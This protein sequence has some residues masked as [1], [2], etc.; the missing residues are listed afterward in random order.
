MTDIIEVTLAA[1]TELKRI[2]SEG[3][4]QPQVRVALKGG[5]CS[6]Y[7]VTMD[8]TKWPPDDDFDH[9]QVTEGFKFFVDGQSI[10]FLRGATLD[11][12]GGLL[13]QGFKW[14]F[15]NATGGCGCG[16]SFSF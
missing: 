13:D 11:Y 6:G 5:G 2:A 4:K 8:F 9:I 1:L 15:P 10:L 12:R 7:T 16:T 14:D 3:N